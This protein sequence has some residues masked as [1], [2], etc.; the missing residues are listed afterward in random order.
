[1]KKEKN[2]EE[3]LKFVSMVAQK[4]GWELNP[5]GPFVELLAQGLSDNFNRYSF[6]QCPCRDSNGQASDNRDIQC[7]CQ[8]AAQ[9]IQEFG[10]CYCALFLS[11]EHL[12]QGLDVEP[13]PERRP[14]ELF[15]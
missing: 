14:E 2:V 12:S 9:D 7:P 6:F 10:H 11:K 13:I 5:D 15:N 4:Q 8:Y 1:M 3:T